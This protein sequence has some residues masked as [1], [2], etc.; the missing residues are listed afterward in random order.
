MK[1]MIEKISLRI[2]FT[3]THQSVGLLHSTIVQY[4][5]R[6]TFNADKF[7]LFLMCSSNEMRNLTT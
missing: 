7:G 6:D 1:E 5:Q 2:I 3:S 4:E